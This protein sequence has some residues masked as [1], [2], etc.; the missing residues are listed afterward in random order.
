M[1]MLS[2]RSVLLVERLLRRHGGHVSARSV[3]EGLGPGFG[4]H[5]TRRP[6]FLSSALTQVRMTPQ[7]VDKV[8]KANEVSET[9]LEGPVKSFDTNT[10]ASNNPIEDS[11]A[12]A[13]LPDGSLLFGI[14]DGHGGAACSQVV[15]K[16][17]FKY[18]CAAFLPSKELEDHHAEVSADSEGV[19]LDHTQ[20]LMTRYRA[21][22]ELELVGEM[23][24][25]SRQSYIKYLEKLPNFQLKSSNV[26]Q[27]VPEVLTK[28][29]LGLDNDLSKEAT[30][31]TSTTYEAM[32]MNMMKI[33]V[34]MSGCVAAVAHVR[35]SNLYV[36]STGR[37][38]LLQY[39][40]TS[41]QKWLFC[42]ELA[43]TFFVPVFF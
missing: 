14:F 42:A 3:A 40:N 10:L 30:S 39:A 36:A 28:S 34:A 31:S 18:I 20:L 21:K 8:L 23:K 12:E 11:H 2:G 43:E 41:E 1:R 32:K 19:K 38:N 24:K 37:G 9:F 15:S 29:F 33:T 35:G 7:E 6:L 16:R 27:D 17:L 5:V 25:V 13:L 22:D 26:P 4:G